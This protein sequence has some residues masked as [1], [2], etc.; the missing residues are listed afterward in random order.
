MP[1]YRYFRD[2]YKE[3]ISCLFITQAI[4]FKAN[5]WLRDV[6]LCNVWPDSSIF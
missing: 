2:K 1:I 4:T 5:P 6:G 3:F